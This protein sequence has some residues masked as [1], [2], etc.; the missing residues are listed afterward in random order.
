MR[1]DGRYAPLTLNIRSLRHHRGAYLYTNVEICAADPR[2][3]LSTASSLCIS[4]LDSPAAV[5]FADRE[6]EIF[7][8]F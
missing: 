3:M 7:V 5:R 2:Y 1:V 8:S 4:P 6:H